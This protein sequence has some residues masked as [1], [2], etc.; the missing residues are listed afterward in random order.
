MFGSLEQGGIPFLN[1]NLSPSLLPSQPVLVR[2]NGFEHLKVRFMSM[3][4]SVPSIISDANPPEP[5]MEPSIVPARAPSHIVQGPVA[6][7]S[8]AVWR[9][10]HHHL[11]HG[12]ITHVVSPSPSPV[13][14][15]DQTCTEP[16]TSTPIGS[17]CGCVFPMKVRLL[18]QVSVYAVFP[19]VNELEIEIATGTYLTQSQVV[20]T[21]ASADTQNQEQTAVDINLVPLGEKFDNTTALLT[22]DRFWRKKLSLNRTLF[23]DYQVVY[24]AYPGLPSSPP[25]GDRAGS[26]PNGSPG[27]RQFPIT[28]NFV[29][30]NQKMNPKTIFVIVLSAVVL[31][32][33]CCAAMSVFIKY[34]RISRSP[35][36]VGPVFTTPSSKRRGLGAMLSSDPSNSTF[37]VI[38]AMPTSLLS[39]K[40]FTLAELEKATEKFSSRKILGEG[41]FGTVYHGIMEDGA[42]VAV[43]LLNRDNNQNGDREFIAEVEMLSRLHHRN[44]VKLIGICIE[45]HTRCLVYELVP[46]GSVE[47]HLHGV[48]K[49]KGPLDWD[50]RLKI[51]LGAA[52]GLAYLHEDSNPRVIHRD[53]K[54]SNVLL[55]DDFTP[56][57]SDFGLA[58]EATEGSSH[59]STRVMGTF[60]Y[61]AP[62]YAM[63]GHLLVKSDVYSYG[64]VLLE[65]LSGRKPVDMSQPP[66]EENLVTWARPLLTTRE[67]LE[68][69]VDR[70][71]SGTYDF[72]DMAKVAAIASMCVHPE[73]TQRPFMGEVVQALKLIYNDKDEVG[74][75]N[76]TQRDSSVVESDFKGDHAPSDSSWWN[77]GGGATPKLI[78]GQASSFI[79][80]DYSSGPLED[81]ENRPF[82]ASSFDGGLGVSLPISHGN[83]SGPLRTVRSK[84][85]FYRSKGSMSE[86]GGLLSKPFWSEASF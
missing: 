25:Y 54:A 24:I 63:T 43:K 85:L 82:S 33:V 73:V 80:M 8:V 1:I 65:L 3:S 12:K 72:D 66:G 68:Q 36:A 46:N 58:R 84:P 53:F 57:V 38:S 70:T 79:T 56:K 10:H 47:S 50:T 5:F 44:L 16:L 17:P 42:E 34:R 37:S 18:L 31:L 71:L 6:G 11:R 83:R 27:N 28:A 61:V 48:D 15:C 13:P 49:E 77:A 69:L 20:I 52:R 81:M 26:G 9:R 29:T 35:T 4:A 23:G 75:D 62:E 67:G 55:E 22:Y 64:V 76:S 78:F 45:G 14:G 19:V 40:T 39:V 59:I 41:G 32:F 74:G 7:P 86:H 51:A 21:G 60:G 30:K 2:R